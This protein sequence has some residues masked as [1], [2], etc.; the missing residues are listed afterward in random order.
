M[1]SVYNINTQRQ[2]IMD[3]WPQKILE[4]HLTQTCHYPI[5]KFLTRTADHRSQAL[6]LPLGSVVEE[7]TLGMLA[8]KTMS[9]QALQSLDF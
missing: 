2:F 1:P 6:S 9:T 5:D 3:D 4:T 7:K 8:E